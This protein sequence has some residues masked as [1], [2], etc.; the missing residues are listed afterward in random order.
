MNS[1]KREWGDITSIST[2]D[3]EDTR[4]SRDVVT[5]KRA[6]RRVTLVPVKRIASILDITGVP[7]QGITIV[8]I[9]AARNIH[10]HLLLLL[11]LFFIVY[12]PN[13]NKAPSIFI[14][15]FFVFH[16]RVLLEGE[17]LVRGKRDGKREEVRLPLFFGLGLWVV[18]PIRV[19]VW[20][21]V[22][23]GVGRG[24]EG[25]RMVWFCVNKRLV[26]EA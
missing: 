21:D 26:S 19:C 8:V 13:H 12:F 17:R 2:A 10:V 25:T 24:V 18:V 15:I 3:H 16:N 23:W 22:F 14:F 6:K 4:G 9:V 11:P 5:N 1:K 20:V 7:V